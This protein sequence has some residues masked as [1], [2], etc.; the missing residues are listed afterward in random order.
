ML[1]HSKLAGYLAAAI[2]LAAVVGWAKFALISN[3]ALLALFAV[4]ALFFVSWRAAS[5]T[6]PGNDPKQ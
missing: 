5:G 3:S 6:W 4:T 2:L 1:D